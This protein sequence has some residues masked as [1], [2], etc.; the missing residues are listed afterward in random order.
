MTLF[1]K[2]WGKEN[3][4]PQTNR[5]GN[6]NTNA[7][8][9]YKYLERV[10]EILKIMTKMLDE[11]DEKL[12]DGL[13]EIRDTLQDYINQLEVILA[14][15]DDYVVDKMVEWLNDGTLEH[16]INH[17]IFQDKLDTFIF[18][19]F[20]ISVNEQ[21]QNIQYL[22]T[23]LGVKTDGTDTT[24]E[25]Q[26][27]INFVLSVGGKLKLPN[28]PMVVTDTI[29]IPIEN[30]KGFAIEGYPNNQTVLRSQVVGKPTLIVYGPAEAGS[31]LSA[32]YNHVESIRIEPF[33]ST[34]DYRI[35]GLVVQNSI[36]NY[37][38]DIYVRKAYEGIKLKN[39]LENGKRGF[40][41]LNKFVNC[42]TSWCDFGFVFDGLDND[43][44]FHGNQFMGCGV[45]AVNLELA[46]TYERT[47]NQ[48]ALDFRK[49]FLYNCRL[50]FTLFL[51]NGATLMYVGCGGYY[52]HATI[53]YENFASQKEGTHPLRPPK[54]TS[55]ETGNS[56]LRLSGDLFGI[57]TPFDTFD[58]TDYHLTDNGGERLVLDTF[59]RPFRA[60]G[61]E[62]NNIVND[63]MRL[64][65]HEEVARNSG[66]L[67]DFYRYNN[68]SNYLSETGLIA[69]VR[70]ERGRFIIANTEPN[71][72]PEE[73]TKVFEFD[74]N[75]TIKY[76]GNQYIRFNETNIESKQGNLLTDKN[77]K[78]GKSVIETGS[79]SGVYS[80][81]F[82]HNQQTIPTGAVATLIGESNGNI[83]DVRVSDFTA[84][85]AKI[86]VYQ[87]D[88]NFRSLQFSWIVFN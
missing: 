16:I 59:K 18:E 24:T 82:Y 33:D 69:V 3:Y 44:S 20:E 58:L 46:K 41:E 10:N 9:Y 85:T 49:G 86:Q 37:F 57:G 56:N 62:H 31:P 19:E 53:T 70:G 14:G 35:G 60:T 79:A 78:T 64:D 38:E 11:Q 25:L 77:I 26:E 84:T 32:R 7:E 5:R 67:V 21:L 61:I 1:N 39:T 55:V 30:A 73:M 40:T 4:Y 76:K 54:I 88:T 29:Y 15:V 22:A 47:F 87:K 48:V 17:E 36:S 74:T 13:Q 51:E 27:A 2:L 65:T 42:T 34:Y 6:F 71:A 52:N 8:S 80:T 23:D 12:D 75:G 72:A 50:D 66:T 63:V 45:T 83:V 43:S 28:K 81:V 68:K